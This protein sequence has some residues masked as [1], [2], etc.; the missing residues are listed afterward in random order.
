MRTRMRTTR[1]TFL[2]EVALL[3]AAFPFGSRAAAA[4]L[5][6]SPD[7][8]EEIVMQK[9]RLVADRSLGTEPIG[10]VMA[11]IGTSFIGTP[12]VA[13]TLEVPGPER[14]VVNLQG[15]DCTTFVEKI[16]ALGAD[17]VISG[18]SGLTQGPAVE[19]L[20]RAGIP[21]VGVSFGYTDVPIA[22]L[23]PDRLIGH[24]KDL[25]HAV[26]SLLKSV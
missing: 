16:V 18:G 22:D 6:G 19:Q 5:E 2:K 13:H 25:P 4:L 8:N 7:R 12:Y 24:M 17:L 26:E 9:F 11:A 14:L 15:L 1:R 23:K 10:E 20:R 3:A 21:V